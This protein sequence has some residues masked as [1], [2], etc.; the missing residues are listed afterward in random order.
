MRNQLLYSQVLR[1]MTPTQLGTGAGSSWK[2][3]LNKLEPTLTGCS[4]LQPV[5][6]STEMTK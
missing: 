3:E 1:A 4:Q 5:A 6:K 2:E